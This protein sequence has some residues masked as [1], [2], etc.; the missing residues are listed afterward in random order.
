MPGKEMGLEF[1]SATGSINGEN[2]SA[3]TK[4][5]LNDTEIRIV[6]RYNIAVFG[7][8]QSA[9]T[10]QIQQALRSEIREVCGVSCECIYTPLKKYLSIVLEHEAYLISGNVDV[11]VLEGIFASMMGAAK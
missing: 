4:Y 2:V 6:S 8:E 9:Y 7:S 1:F 11:S 5:R 3:T 10:V